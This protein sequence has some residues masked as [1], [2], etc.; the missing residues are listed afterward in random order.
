LLGGKAI[1][2]ATF[3]AVRDISPQRRKIEIEPVG[4]ERP[5]P[6]FI[7]RKTKMEIAFLG[8]RKE[9]KRR[10]SGSAKAENWEID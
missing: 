10:K 4:E 1:G 6:A 2:L 8:G 3:G 9:R 7:L 5:A